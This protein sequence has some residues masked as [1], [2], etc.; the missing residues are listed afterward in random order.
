MKK[1]DITIFLYA[2]RNGRDSKQLALESILQY[3]KKSGRPLPGVHIVCGAHGKPELSPPC[4][5]HFSISHTKN[6]WACACA[7]TPVG[8]DI[9]WERPCDQAALARRFFHPQ[10]AEFVQNDPS[11][12]FEV[13]TA[14]ESYVKWSGQGITD[15]FGAFS[16]VADK[17]LAGRIKDAELRHISW[18]G[19]Y[20][21]C[22]C[23]RQ[24]GRIEKQTQE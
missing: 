15:D 6:V 5:I 18:R 14:K 16:T 19:G 7:D 12:F 13:W 2:N 4:G 22:V 10:E 20:R 24:I 21:M 23:A 8:L 1:Y 3:A 17:T 11:R 9:E